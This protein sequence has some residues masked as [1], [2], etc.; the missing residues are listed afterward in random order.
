MNQQAL[1]IAPSLFGLITTY[2]D[3]INKG[4]VSVK[5]PLKRTTPIVEFCRTFFQQFFENELGHE[6][7]SI[8]QQAKFEATH[9]RHDLD[10]NPE[11]KALEL[12]IGW[13]EELCDIWPDV[14]GFSYGGSA[15]EFRNFHTIYVPRLLERLIVWA[16]ARGFD[17]IVA[18]AEEALRLYEPAVKKLFQS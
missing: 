1:P 2:V 15:T 7:T 3:Q 14:L 18:S 6:I 4:K 13:F 11:T 8:D 5:S 9:L 17:E 16:K 10:N 12:L